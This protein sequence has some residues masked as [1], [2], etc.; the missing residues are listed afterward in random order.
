V[1]GGGGGTKT[2]AKGTQ[3]LEGFPEWMSYKLAGQF[4]AALAWM[5]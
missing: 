1:G 5:P 4:S 2:C 3:G